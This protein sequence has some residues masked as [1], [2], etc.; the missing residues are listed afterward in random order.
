MSCV[1]HTLIALG[2]ALALPALTFLP[3]RRRRHPNRRHAP[4]L[5]WRQ[6]RARPRSAVHGGRRP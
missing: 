6:P 5:L 1:Q 2:M 3:N 4:V